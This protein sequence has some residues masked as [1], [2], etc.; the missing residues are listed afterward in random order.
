MASS[1]GNMN[2][3]MNAFNSNN[4]S[5]SSSQFMTSSFSDL[6]SDNDNNN[7]KNWGF[8]DQ[9]IMNNSNKDEIPKF[10]SFPPSSL[11]MISSSSPASPSSYL[12][13][14]PSL[15]P[16]VL[17]DSPVMFNNS[18][19]LA[20]PTTGSFGNMNSKE[21]NS[22]TC[23]FSF[24]SRPATSSSMFQ[25]S[26]PR[27]SL[28][29]LMIRQQHTNEFSATKL[30]GVKSEVAPIQIFS[31]DNM[32]NDPTP[33]HYCQPAQY[34]REQ[35]AEDGYNWRKYGQKQ[36]KGSENPRS[37]YKCTFPNCPTKKKVERNLDGHIT[38]IVYKG[39]H[40]HPKP[41]S[42]RR[43]SSQSIQNLAYNSNLDITN[44][45]NAF[46]ENAHRDSLAVA[47]N[48]SASFGEEDVDQGS[49]ISKSGEND[50]NEPEAK[51]WKG[52][53][54]NEVISSA[55]RTVREPRI[56]V[57]T[58]SDIDI[59][60]DGY[61]WRKY[62]QKVVKGNPN[63]RSYYKCTFTGCPVRKHV[64][65]ASHDLR[66][67][68]TTYEGKHNHDV[69]AARGSG[70][71]A[72]NKPPSGNNNNNNHM[73]IVSRPSVLTSHSNQGMNFN[74]TFFNNTT[75]NQPPITLQMLQSSESTS[76]YSGFGTSSGSYMN[77]MQHM[78]KP[79]SKEEPKDDLF[80]NSFLN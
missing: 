80:F 73:P 29:D 12:A 65:R 78:N 54:E 45:A 27:K 13:F 68:I 38:E 64:E 40:N 76:S 10:K 21:D 23:D 7:N 77:Q 55:S 41:Q 30:T 53:N 60:D 52:D 70:S 72:M 11:P 6:L 63:P 33:V 9:R 75:Q 37:Y 59:L 48:S 35:K 66:A 61:R 74:D 47:D 4:Y 18:N 56:V 67:V 57:Q 58:T 14:P 34:V 51:R 28:E 17:L 44:Q 2:T 20:S 46:H 5:F 8:S 24:Q 32:Q 49:P 39:S 16:S 43:S 22:R 69:P 31:Q 36:V 15:S 19:T 42:T 3:F 79:I 62:G 25:S 1:G 26:A 50:E 71:Y